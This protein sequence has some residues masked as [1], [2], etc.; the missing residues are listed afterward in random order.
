MQGTEGD[1]GLVVTPSS[2]HGGQAALHPSH[3]TPPFQLTHLTPDPL[4]TRMPSYTPELG[5]IAAGAHRPPSD[6]ILDESTPLHNPRDPSHRTL[7]ATSRCGPSGSA[8]VKGRWKQPTPYY[9]EEKNSWPH[10]GPHTHRP[11]TSGAPHSRARRLLDRIPG[12]FLHT[13]RPPSSSPGPIALR[14]NALRTG[15]LQGPRGLLHRSQVRSAHQSARERMPKFASRPKQQSLRRQS[16]V[17]DSPA[18]GAWDRGTPG[19]ESPY[20]PRQ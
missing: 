19:S 8:E 1:S 5:A 10:T 7:S 11:A 18:P 15:I 17:A 20:P 4:G 12:V 9:T 6:F 2:R 13:S 16:H 3:A 14:G